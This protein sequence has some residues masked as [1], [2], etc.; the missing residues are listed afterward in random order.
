ML[1]SFAIQPLSVLHGT[2]FLLLKIKC[3]CRSFCQK[4]LIFETFLW[5]RQERLLRE[6]TEYQ[7]M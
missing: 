3:D 2:P 1:I 4:L 7:S 5:Q 6:T